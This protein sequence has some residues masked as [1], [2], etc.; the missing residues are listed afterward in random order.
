MLCLRFWHLRSDTS[1]RSNKVAWAAYGYE[2]ATH[3]YL[4]S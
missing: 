4:D 1:T 3:L 2:S